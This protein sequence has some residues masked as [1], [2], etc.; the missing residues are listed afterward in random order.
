[1]NRLKSPMDLRRSLVLG[2][3]TTCL[4]VFLGQGLSA[5]TQAIGWL[6][7]KQTQGQV[8]L[9]ASPPRVARVGD[10]L[11]K[12]GDS[13]RTGPNSS[14]ILRL[15]QKIGMINVAE[16]TLL[17]IQRLGRLR[18]GAR[19]TTLALD[20]GQVRLNVRRFHNPASRLEITS[21]AGVAA[22]RGTEY[23][24]SLDGDNRMIVATES[25]LVTATAQGKTVF[26]EPDFG[27]RLRPNEQP[28]APQL[29]D[30]ELALEL[31]RTEI[32]DRQ[33][34]VSGRVHPLNSVIVVG[35]EVPIDDQGQFEANLTLPNSTSLFEFE[36]KVKNAL[37]ESRSYSI[38]GG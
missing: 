30:R 17:R 27:S 18:S 32:N 10:R 6:E 31:N 29:L 19:V 21:P 12:V 22:V 34:Y 24:I 25:G 20:Q 35:V 3:L 37:G 26:L 4:V 2:F 8:V 11:S 38:I 9:T 14:A 13:L 1:M 33:L 36:I 5:Q 15:D 7:V 28:S 16:N 23:G